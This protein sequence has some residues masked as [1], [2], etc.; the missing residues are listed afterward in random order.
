MEELG[1]HTLTVLRAPFKTDTYGNDDIERDWDAATRTDWEGCSVQPTGADEYVVD[2]EAV[3]V[4]YRAF[5]PG[6][7]PIPSPVEGEEPSPA[8]STDRVEWKGEQ[9]YVDG[10]EFWDFEPLG[11]TDLLLRKVAG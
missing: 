3:V 2:R 11:H 5:C 10:A 1:P 4:R 9:Y 6:S 8:V 7:K